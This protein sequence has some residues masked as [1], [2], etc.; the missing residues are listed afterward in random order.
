MIVPMYAT[1]SAQVVTKLVEVREEGG[2]SALGR[3]LTLVIHCPPAEIEASVQ[4]ANSA[5]MEHPCRII[6]VTAE[7]PEGP[8]A[9]DA[10]I[11]VGSDAGASEVVVLRVRGEPGEHLD[12]VV[13]PL[14]LPDTPVVVWWPAGRPDVPAESP[15]GRLAER[16]ITDAQRSGERMAALHQLAEGYR[17]GDTDLAWTRL[18]PW[19]AELAAALSI[20]PRE[21]VT[22]ATVSGPAGP[23]TDL[24]AVWLG[25]RLGVPVRC[26]VSTTDYINSVALH[27]AGGGRLLLDK[28]NQETGARLRIT[29]QPDRVVALG[30]RSRAES[31][32]E[33]LRRLEPDVAYGN[34]VTQNLPVFLAKQA[35]A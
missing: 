17:P 13:T 25:T 20:P 5:S 18:T 24:M 4:S 34:L 10:Q 27:R 26:T 11:R 23:S 3:V 28:E 31:L 6:L 22:S 2:V 12:A 1:T 33:E 30:R 16:R 32:A 15:L 14:L 29:D 21:R 8:P 9:M 19:R 7:D 35:A